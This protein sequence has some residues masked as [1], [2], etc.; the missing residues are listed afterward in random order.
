M[1]KPKVYVTGVG[2]TPFIKPG[3]CATMSDYYY[4]ENL[5]RKDIDYVDLGVLAIQRALRDA[6]ISGQGRCL[7]ITCLALVSQILMRHMLDTCMVIVHVVNESSI[8]PLA[9]PVYLL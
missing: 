4:S 7:V 9:V 8:K 2:M 6:G 1:T 5:L 3:R